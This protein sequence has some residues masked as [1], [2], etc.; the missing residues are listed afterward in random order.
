MSTDFAPSQATYATS[1]ARRFHFREVAE[2]NDD[3]SGLPPAKDWETW[4][5][6]IAKWE[7]CA[8]QEDSDGV[9]WP[10]VEAIA[11]ARQLI[12]QMRRKKEFPEPTDLV[13]AGDGGIVFSRRTGDIREEIEIFESGDAELLLFQDS[14]LM[15][16]TPL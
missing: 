15:H 5:V 10:T 7:S 3:T 2:S 6:R 4:L 8:G 1:E 13:P 12:D 11:A 16:R 14:R 9:V